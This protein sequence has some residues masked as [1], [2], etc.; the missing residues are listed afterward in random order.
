L[1]HRRRIRIELTDTEDLRVAVY[2]KS[3]GRV[4]RWRRWGR[5]LAGRG[6]EGMQEFAMTMTLAEKGIPVARPIAFGQESRCGRSYVMLE[7]L[8]RADALERLLAPGH[9][10]SRDYDVLADRNRLGREAAILVR[11]L[12]GA[13]WFH[14]DLYLSHL[15]LSRDD[16]GVERLNLI[17][18]QRV[19]RPLWRR[20]RWRVKDLA[21]LGY[22]AGPLVSRTDMLRFFLRYRQQCRLEPRDK[23]LARA[24]GR[25]MR[26]IARHDARRV[27][28][29]QQ[30]AGGPT[31]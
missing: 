14:R 18:L 19:F 6:A 23:R 1:G 4:G 12:H 25:R 7:E 17:D 31:P 3:F 16:H 13:G 5:W 2:L 8:P 10:G 28:R 21:Q 27:A 15:F 9:P 20:A 11:R 22:S 29:R 24:I 30:T 26:R